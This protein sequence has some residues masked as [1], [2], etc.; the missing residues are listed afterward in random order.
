MNSLIIF[1]EEINGSIATIKGAHLKYLQ[2]L[3]DLKVGRNISVA[4]L[5]GQI[6]KGIITTSNK[7]EVIIEISLNSLPPLREP[8]SLIV[9]IPRP[10]TQ[11]KIIHLATVL[12]I[13]E[14]HFVRC[15]NS[16]KSYLSSHILRQE[17]LLYELIKGLEQCCDSTPPT[18]KV[19]PFFKAFIDDYLK[20]QINNDPTAT[21][22]ICDTTPLDQNLKLSSICKLNKG[23]PCQI[24]IGPESG[25]NDFEREEFKK[26]G[27]KGDQFRTKDSTLRNCYLNYLSSD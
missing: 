18:V 1:K 27:F 15:E 3:H 19:H 7:L 20:I 25:W 24:A 13:S 8:T 16:E 17:D 6:G 10:Q 9:A 23:S 4:Q 21:S 2:D 5:Y 26:L 11:K 14:L 22:I 12:G